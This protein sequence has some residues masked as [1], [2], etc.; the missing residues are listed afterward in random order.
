MADFFSAFQTEWMNTIHAV[1][2][3]ILLPAPSVNSNFYTGLQALRAN[4]VTRM[5][6]TDPA[7]P[8][9]MLAFGTFIQDPGWAMDRAVRW[10]PVT[11]FY[12]DCDGNEADQRTVNAKLYTLADYVFTHAFTTFTEIHQGTIDSSDTNP[13]NAVLPVESNVRAVGGYVTWAQGIMP[14]DNS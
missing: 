10:A 8:V 13:V 9:A 7:F 2:P 11:V 14:L 12:L 3:E 5:E 1:W 6:D 4:I